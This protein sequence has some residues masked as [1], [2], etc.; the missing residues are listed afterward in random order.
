[1]YCDEFMELSPAALTELLQRVSLR[2]L[3]E[4]AIFEAVMSWVRHD[5]D[6]RREVI[7][8]ILLDTV[9]SACLNMTV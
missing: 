1:M 3:G 5:L 2:V 7:K 9:R 8:Q 6:S 4:T